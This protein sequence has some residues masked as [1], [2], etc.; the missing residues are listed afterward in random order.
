MMANNYRDMDVMPQF[1]GDMVRG[2]LAGAHE[3]LTLG[4][5]GRS[6]RAAIGH[7]IDFRTWQSLDEHGLDPDEAADL[8]TTMITRLD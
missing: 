4:W 7:A 1:V 3:A 2:F 6:R 8:M 5:P